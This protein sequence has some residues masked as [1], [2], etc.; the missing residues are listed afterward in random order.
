MGEP[1]RGSAPAAQERVRRICHALRSMAC[2]MCQDEGR[3]DTSTQ[4][5]RRTASNKGL[6]LELGA[7]DSCR[8]TLGGAARSRL[9]GRAPY[10]A[11]HMDASDLIKALQKTL[12]G[13]GRPHRGSGCDGHWRTTVVGSLEALP[14]AGAE[15]T[16]VDCTA[17]LEQPDPQFRG[18]PVA[19]QLRRD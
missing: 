1:A 4:R 19:Q 7:S 16:I 8:L 10:K 12:R 2:R 14:E 9:T 13:G 3:P 17:D 11:G 15:C 18:S 6:R 5:A